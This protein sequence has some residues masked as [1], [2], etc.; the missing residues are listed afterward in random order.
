M[1]VLEGGKRLIIPRTELT[2]PSHSMR[3]HENAARAAVDEVMADFEDAC[4]YE[5]KGE[6]SRKTMVEALNTV[7]FGRKV[8]TIR[9]N[10]TRSPF[11][12][13][14][15][16]AIMLGAPDRFHGI[17]LPKCNE[18]EDIVYLS[19]LLD[20]LEQQGGWKTR[21]QIEALIESPLAIVNAYKI[22]TASPRMAGLV[23]GI[24]DFVASIGV[25]EMVKDQNKNFHYVKQAVVVAAKAAGLHA[26][27]NAYLTISRKD[28]PEEESRRIREELRQKNIEAANLGMDG[29]WIIHP[30]Q[31]EIA[32]ECFTPNSARIGAAKR[33]LEYYHEHGGGALME[34]ETGEFL[35]EAVIKAL[36]MLLAKGVQAGVVD[37]AYLAKHAQKSKAISGYDILETSGQVR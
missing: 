12:L 2:Y 22:A 9:P 17:I 21:V 37:P 20:T 11:F 10:N 29:T 7:D 35:D 19:R 27:D 15:I 24:A 5:F 34:P 6:A 28:M 33:S 13:G 31:A 4:P 25:H 1:F 14:D 18:P 26:V 16:E 32:N 23:F 8:V 3:M 30:Q 36:L